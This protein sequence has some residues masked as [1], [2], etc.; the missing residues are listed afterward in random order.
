VDD[1]DYVPGPYWSVLD[2]LSGGFAFVEYAAS[3]YASASAK[4]SLLYRTL[5]EAWTTFRPQDIE[6]GDWEEAVCL[7]TDTDECRRFY[8]PDGADAG[9]DE[10]PD[11]NFTFTGAGII[12]REIPFIAS[13]P[14]PECPNGLVDF[15]TG[16]T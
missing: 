15:D 13:P 8:Y 4:K 6:T 9:G 5:P 11:K 10:P 14:Y 2:I 7:G 3:T 12:Y 1:E 16:C